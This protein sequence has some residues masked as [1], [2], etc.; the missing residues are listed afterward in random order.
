MN[1]MKTQDQLNFDRIAEAIAYIQANFKKQPGLE[2]IAAQVISVPSISSAC[3]PN[4]PVPA[5]RNFCNTS[6]SNTPNRY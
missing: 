6:A 3:L 2:E 1:D 4:G 5:R